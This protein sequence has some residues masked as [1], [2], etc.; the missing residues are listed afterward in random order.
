M[1][2]ETRL[3]ARRLPVWTLVIGAFALIIFYFPQLGELLVYDRAAISHGEIWRLLTGNLVH[4]S[5]AHLLYN[6]IAWLIIGTIIEFRA[7][8]FFPV[9][10][11]SSAL[12]VGITLFILEPELYL[13]AGLSGVVSAAVA[14]LCLHGIG[15]KGV[16][17]WLCA[18]TLAGL[19]AKTLIELG[20]RSSFMLLMSEEN[21]VPVPLSHLA[22]IIA[23]LLLFFLL[24][25]TSALSRSSS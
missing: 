21:F 18:A 13:Y 19:T 12:L 2:Q 16:W 25:M 5:L 14:Y 9:L 20:M 7:Y 11:F 6:L 3:T 1:E 24:R 23:A 4:F 15:E 22:G 8:R 17:R 10:C